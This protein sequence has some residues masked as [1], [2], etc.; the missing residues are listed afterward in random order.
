M[1]EIKAGGYVPA[2][3]APIFEFLA[4]LEN[5]WQLAGPFIEVVGLERPSGQSDAPA[6]GGRVRMRG[7]LGL[8]RTAHT[9]WS[10]PCRRPGCAG[11][12]G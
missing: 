11:R 1:R 2:P 9:G 12:Q 5:H 10:P 3:R 4:D 6:V 8:W 7:P